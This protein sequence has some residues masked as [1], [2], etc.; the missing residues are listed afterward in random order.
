M[1]KTLLIIGVCLLAGIF[2]YHLIAPY[3][4][5]PTLNLSGLLAR[6]QLPDL[7]SVTTITTFLT[8]HGAQVLTLTSLSL[9][10][11]GIIYAKV[12][13]AKV[14]AA[15]AAAQA[16]LLAS[17]NHILDQYN[18]NLTLQTEN[19]TLEKTIEGLQGQVGNTSE[20]L[21]KVE[22]QAQQIQSLTTLNN[23]LSELVPNQQ[24]QDEIKRILETMKKVP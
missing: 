20:L 9:G 6:F 12:K 16:K 13:E 8:E 18:Q 24:T 7:S 19:L 17:N 15:E 5:V 23:H 22:S 10:I 11:G 21:S 14:K 4:G 2:T 3:M 1:L